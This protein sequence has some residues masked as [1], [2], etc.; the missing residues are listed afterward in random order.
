MKAWLILVLALVVVSCSSGSKLDSQPTITTGT[1]EVAA[2][3]STQ[4]DAP[5]TTP[6]STTSTTTAETTTTLAASTTTT[7]TGGI[8]DLG[9][10]CGV[11]EAWVQAAAA[12]DWAASWELTHPFT[13]T[14]IPLESPN[15]GYAAG[16]PASPSNIAYQDETAQSASFWATVTD[17]TCT[18]FPFGSSWDTDIGVVTLSGTELGGLVAGA[19]EVRTDSGQ[20]KID[21]FS[22]FV[23]VEVPELNVPIAPTD[24]IWFKTPLGTLDAAVLLDGAEI[25]YTLDE[26]PSDLDSGRVTGT[27]PATLDS[28]TYVLTVL[29]LLENGVLDATAQVFDVN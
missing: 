23:S 20:W 8:V 24:L 19:Y 28:G 5:A 13:Q 10:P 17:P 14:G 26:H 2:V 12:E 21:N 15:G 4:S 22:I 11:I 16:G 3:S 7:A 29:A 1:T 6:A 18:F 25:P 9:T 27:P